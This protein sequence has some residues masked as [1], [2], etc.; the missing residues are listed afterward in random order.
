[1][2]RMLVVVFAACS[3]AFAASNAV[4]SARPDKPA[5][6]AG[7]PLMVILTVKNLSGSDIGLTGDP[8]DFPRVVTGAGVELRSEPFPL[9]E[10][11][12]VVAAVAKPGEVASVTIVAMETAQ[13]R[14]PGEYRMT[15]TVPRLD[16]SSDLSFT[17]L[18]ANPAALARRADEFYDLTVGVSLES[19]RAMRA[20]EAMAPGVSVPRLCA[21]L[22]RYSGWLGGLLSYRLVQIGSPEVV[23]CLIE[24]LPG[25]RD[26]VSAASAVN[27]LER[28]AKKT[29]DPALREKIQRALP[30]D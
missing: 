25:I 10:Q 22:R 7:E 9:L 8:Y 20:L 27:S 28:I 30:T 23:D 3:L 13:L 4:L 1:M 29:T 26:A 2:L 14:R 19:Q 5:I 15:V 24:I 17:V 21:V 18:P 6:L 11:G 16:L 12:R